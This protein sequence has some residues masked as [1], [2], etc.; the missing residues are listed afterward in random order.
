MSD[1]EFSDSNKIIN[2]QNV[3]SVVSY[4]YLGVSTNQTLKI[5]PAPIRDDGTGEQI[6]TRFRT[7]SDGIRST[8]II[9]VNYA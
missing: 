5:Y 6:G 9:L 1:D 4:V 3:S 2:Q 7:K 8:Y